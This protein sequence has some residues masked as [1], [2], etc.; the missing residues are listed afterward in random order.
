VTR[1][2]REQHQ[3]HARHVD[4]ATTHRFHLLFTEHRV[5][6]VNERLTVGESSK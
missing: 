1:R 2:I 4:D 6:L 3:P 5:D